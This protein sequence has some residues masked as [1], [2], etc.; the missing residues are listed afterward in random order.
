M[1]RM[2]NLEPGPKRRRPQFLVSWYCTRPGL[3]ALDQLLQ[4]DTFPFGHLPGPQAAP[5]VKPEREALGLLLPPLAPLRVLPRPGA[6]PPAHRTVG[7]PSAWSCPLTGFNTRGPSEPRRLAPTRL[8]YPEPVLTTQGR[9]R[10]RQ[11]SHAGPTT[12]HFSSL[13]T[14]KT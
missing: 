11:R 3:T 2:T 10:R 7:A 13:F 14:A 9:C 4:T 6:W 8:T 12:A 1:P 5:C